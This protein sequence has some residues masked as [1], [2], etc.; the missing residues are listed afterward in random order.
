M[1]E[2]KKLSGELLAEVSRWWMVRGMGGS[3]LERFWRERMVAVG[4]ETPNVDLSGLSD[5]SGLRSRLQDPGTGRPL[6]EER[7][8]REI[9]DFV[10][11]MQIGDVVVTPGKSTS[12]VLIGTVTGPVSYDPKAAGG[13]HAQRAVNWRKRPEVPSPVRQVLSQPQIATFQ[14]NEGQ[15]AALIE[16]ISPKVR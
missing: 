16:I 9:C 7:R 14:L 1:P 11:R 8:F 3:L 4:S 10:L 12:E 5:E 13:V 15:R 2:S 6:V